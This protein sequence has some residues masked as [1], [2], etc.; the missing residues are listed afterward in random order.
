MI[1]VKVTGSFKKTEKLLD[2]I[3]KRDMFSV[4]DSMGRKGV[5]ALAAATP[6][7]S[8]VTA[9]SW[10]YSIINSA[11]GVSI[12]WFNTNE[13]DGVN[14]AIILQYGHGTGTGGF[15]QGQD[16]INPAMKPIFDEIAERVWKEVTA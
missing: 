3:L 11:G 9:N 6:I 14:I 16:Y 13:V 1:K 4:L 15:V 10:E 12:T 8:G 5:E 7:E 2:R